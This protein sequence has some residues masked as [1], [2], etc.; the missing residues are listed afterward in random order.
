[1]KTENTNDIV[2]ARIQKQTAQKVASQSF[3][4]ANAMGADLV[5]LHVM[6]DVSVNPS[7]ERITIM[8]FNG[9]K[10]N[11][12]AQSKC[13]DELKISGKSPLPMP[14]PNNGDFSIKMMLQ[15]ADFTE[16]VLK[17]AQDLH[18]ELLFWAQSDRSNCKIV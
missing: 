9:F 7:F 14:T 15:E 3:S 2:V 13:C 4:L 16:S 5:L 12:A 11:L 6:S 1:M 17:A 10:N 8:G 18:A